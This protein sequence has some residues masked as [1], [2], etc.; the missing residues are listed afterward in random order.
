VFDRNNWH[1]EQMG[2]GGLMEPLFDFMAQTLVPR[3]TE[4]AS[5]WY[6]V[7]GWVAFTSVNIFGHTG[8]VVKN[9]TPLLNLDSGTGS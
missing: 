2:L 4:S 7:T 8:S 5:L 3:G 1:A 9:I 6:N